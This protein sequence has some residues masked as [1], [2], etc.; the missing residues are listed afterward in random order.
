MH[1]FHRMVL[2]ML[3]GPILAWLGMLMFMLVMQFLIK[4]LPDLV[5]KGLPVLAVVELVAYNL[6]YMLV[7]AVPMS[8][9]IASLMSFGKLAESGTWAVIKGAG[10]SFLQLVWPV[11][12]V[13]LL[14]TLAMGYFN[15]VVLPEANFRARNLWQDIRMARPG[16]QLKPGVFYDGLDD[17]RILVRNIP[18]EAPNE[19]EDVIIYDYTE[20]PRYRVD[21]K[22]KRGRLETVAGGSLLEIMLN[23]G[24]IHRLKPPGS[25]NDDRYERLAFQQH[26]MLLSLDDLSFERSNP[27]QGRRTDRTM[28]TEDMKNLVDSMD[29]EIGEAKAASALM[30]KNLGTRGP[31]P[32]DQARGP[33]SLEIP[34]SAPAAESPWRSLQ[35]LDQATISQV[36]Q[37][38][39]QDA[40]STHTRLERNRR[41]IAATADR[42]DRYRVEIHKKYSIALA[43]LIF[44]LVGVPL[45]LR[46]RRGGLATAALLALGI[47]MFYWVALV[48]G[49]KFADRGF[50]EPWVGMWAANMVMGAIGVWLM[51]RVSLD[52]GGPRFSIP[53]LNRRPAGASG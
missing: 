49:E 28:R 13:G 24:E 53:F 14:M 45:G 25:G 30:L 20:G 27:N 35:G 6:A 39:L 21:I 47:F 26:R 11:L 51:V 50:I 48:N 42:A 36:A 3:P 9:L 34:T 5:G 23:E 15:N 2:R 33:V 16:F 38:A 12:V 8:V 18:P 29:V 41:V 52:R 10:V 19:L 43:C 40:R 46:I 31:D 37:F 17:Y 32:N 22:A 1:Q 4:Y 7:L 44:M